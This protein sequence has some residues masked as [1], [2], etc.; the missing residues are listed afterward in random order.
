[1]K[2]NVSAILRNSAWLLFDRVI[3]LFGAFFVNAW[4]ARYLGPN[5]YGVIA[6][7]LA[8]IALFWGVVNLG[9]DAITVRE[10]SKNKGNAG[11][12]FGSVFVSRL[13]CGL[14]IYIIVFIF[15]GFKGDG[16]NLLLYW[17]VA[18]L[19]IL[20]QSLD[21]CDLWFQSQSKSKLTVFAKLVAFLCSS[22]IKILFIKYECDLIYFIFAML[23]ESIVYAISL[24]Y[25]FMQNQPDFKIKFSLNTAKNILR[26]SW[27]VLLCG[28]G[29]FLY[30][31]SD[32]LVIEHFWGSGMLGIYVASI[33]F[34][35]M[36]TAFP[37]ILY[38][39]LTPHL[40]R[41]H[42]EDANKFDSILSRLFRYSIFFTLI[43]C[44]LV[45]FCSE[46]FIAS[47]FGDA[48]IQGT[49]ALQIHVFTN[50]FIFLGIIQSIWFTVKMKTKL[51][52]PKI[53]VGAAIGFSLNLLF[54]PKFGI[55]GAAFSALISIVITDF[56]LIRLICP[57]LFEL[58]IR[59]PIK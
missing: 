57:K 22:A 4:V 33:S 58:M 35:Q 39:S 8:S 43:L 38:I 15:L 32:Q 21:V 5:D 26:E 45:C 59:A 37:T 12:L 34:S 10:L 28:P 41:I 9:A 48:Y 6:Y 14:I 50:V 25:V 30:S 3:K 49:N 7:I 53:A 51:M 24:I 23:F 44:L 17:S 20:L 11:D 27:P 36:L 40:T 56:V 47:I 46:L 1:M 31:R 16:R 54:I 19:A 18:G 13:V 55:S 2:I 42:E 52:L 29:T